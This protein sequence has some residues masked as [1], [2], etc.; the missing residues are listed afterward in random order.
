M[1]IAN[2]LYRL[3]ES[4]KVKPSVYPEVWDLVN[5]SAGLEALEKRKTWGKVVVRIRNDDV[6][7]KL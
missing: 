1:L 6:D 3:F 7:A 4:G 2:N 5:I